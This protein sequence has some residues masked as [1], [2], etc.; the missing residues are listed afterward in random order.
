MIFAFSMFGALISILLIG[1]MSEL[2]KIRALMEE[3]NKK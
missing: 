3:Q 1:C 2:M